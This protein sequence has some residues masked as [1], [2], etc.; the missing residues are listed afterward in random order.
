MPKSLDEVKRTFGNKLLF[1][2]LPNGLFFKQSEI[3]T[4]MQ[5][6]AFKKEGIE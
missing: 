2:K 3:V 1:E 6:V 4:D 5:S